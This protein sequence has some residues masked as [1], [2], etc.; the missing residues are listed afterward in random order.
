ML[1]LLSV[2]LSFSTTVHRPHPVI[3]HC[4]HRYCGAACWCK[5]LFPSQSLFCSLPTT[6]L[7]LS[8]LNSRSLPLSLLTLNSCLSLNLIILIFDSLNFCRI[9]EILCKEIANCW[10]PSMSFYPRFSLYNSVEKFI[11]LVC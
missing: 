2:F 7:S 8:T 5:A 1:S 9:L 6:S 10:T 11:Y 3:R 4:P